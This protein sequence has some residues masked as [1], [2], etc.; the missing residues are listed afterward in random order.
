[1][2]QHGAGRD[3]E[4]VRQH[5]AV[6]VLAGRGHFRGDLGYLLVV[7]LPTDSTTATEGPQGKYGTIAHLLGLT[8]TATWP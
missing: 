8:L 3:A 1:V 5:A 2:D 4:R 6:E 7:F